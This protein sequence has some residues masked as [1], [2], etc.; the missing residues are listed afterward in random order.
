[1]SNCGH[2]R[3]HSHPLARNIIFEATVDAAVAFDVG[4]APRAIHS[5]T[6]CTGYTQHHIN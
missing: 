3:N 6:S 5:S 4:A 2:T 1:M